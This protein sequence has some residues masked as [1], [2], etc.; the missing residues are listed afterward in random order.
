MEP[1]AFAVLASANAV[2]VL[3]WWRGLLPA[4]RP[5]RP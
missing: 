5:A 4:P 1:L 2:W 3:C